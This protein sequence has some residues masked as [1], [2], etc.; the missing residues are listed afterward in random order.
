M[1]VGEFQKAIAASSS[2]YSSFMKKT[3]SMGSVGSCVYGNA[4]VFFELGELTGEKRKRKAKVGG[5]GEVKGKVEAKGEDFKGL[6]LEGEGDGQV[7]V[8]E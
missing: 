8:F 4:F 7:P 5:D 3:D 1:K 6:V 2:T